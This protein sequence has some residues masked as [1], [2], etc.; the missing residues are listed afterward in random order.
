M[1]SVRLTERENVLA[2]GEEADWH[3]EEAG[4][5]ITVRLAEDTGETTVEITFRPQCEACTPQ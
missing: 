1:I 2:N 4:V 3:H 5:T